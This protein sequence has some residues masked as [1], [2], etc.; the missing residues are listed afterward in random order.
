MDCYLVIWFGGYKI[1]KTFGVLAKFI[2][3]PDPSVG[4]RIRL[5]HNSLV[6][7]IQH[8]DNRYI[9]VNF[10]IFGVCSPAVLRI[11]SAD[12]QVSGH[13]DDH[14]HFEHRNCISL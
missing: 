11:F 1:H 6:K 9:F 3:Q 12:L 2:Q 14:Q 4:D 10:W 5:L 13:N 7:K 8:R